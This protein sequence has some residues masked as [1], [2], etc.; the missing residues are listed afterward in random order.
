M[1]NSI[2]QSLCGHFDKRRL[3]RCLFYV[4]SVTVLSVDVTAEFHQE[5]YYLQV[6]RADGVVQ[7]RDAFVVGRARIRHLRQLK[8]KGNE[9]N[10]KEWDTRTNKQSLTGAICGIDS[11][12]RTYLEG[13][14]LDELQF[15]LERRVQQ[16]R[17]R[18][19]TDA[20]RLS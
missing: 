14:F 2:H 20:T 15:T 19:E 9:K 10:V 18:I 17:Q 12:T 4:P 8:K 6:A 11:H 7:C 16:Q 5:T 3:V 1:S 13:R